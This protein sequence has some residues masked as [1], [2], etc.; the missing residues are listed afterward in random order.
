LNIFFNLNISKKIKSKPF[1]KIDFFQNQKTNVNRIKK[2]KRKRE[3]TR[4]GWKTDS[5]MG[6]ADATT[7]CAAWCNHKSVKPIYCEG[8]YATLANGAIWAATPHA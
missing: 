2:H 7:G 3:R 4:N 6:Q 5:N 1:S 8:E